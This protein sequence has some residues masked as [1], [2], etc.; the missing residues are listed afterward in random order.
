M[1]DELLF[2]TAYDRNGCQ[3][4]WVHIGYG[5]FHRAHQAVY[6]DD[7]MQKT[8]DLGWGVAAVNLR[9]SE[10]DVFQT[11]QTEEGYVLKSI[12]PSGDEAYRL[13]RSHLMFVDAAQDLETALALFACPSVHVVSMTITESGYAFTDDWRLDLT[14]EAVQADRA[15]QAPR[16]IYG[17]LAAA[18]DRRAR[19]SG[20]PLTVLCCDNIRNNGRLVEEAVHD[21]LQAAGH[22]ELAGWV[23]QNVTFPCSMVDRITP[24]SSDALVSEVADRF[25]DHAVAPV[26]AEDFS[27]WVLQDRFA[28]PMPDLARVGVQVVPNVEPFEEAKIRILNGGHTALAYFAALAGHKTFDQAMHDPRIRTH[29]DRWEMAEVLPGLNG[30]VPFDTADYLSQIACRFENA[31]IADQVERICT[32]GYAKMA[33]YIRPTMSACLDQGITPRAGYDS[34]AAWVVYARKH[35]A[36]K[37]QIPYHEPLWD[38]LSP[39]IEKG[40]EHDLAAD[41]HLWGDLPVRHDGFVPGVVA[42]IQQME[43]QWQG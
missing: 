9:A 37:A 30:I 35:K 16:T 11:A 25:P 40:R 10:S 24:R 32:D 41:R 28:G 13:V 21:F 42:A 18:F 43:D 26:H 38:K 39:L 7:Y 12:A 5:A 20:A 19:G 22:T 6:L 29:F 8:G 2:R 27:Q 3:I 36:G 33:I 34:I 4:G 17:F 14:A 15:L 23:R 31:G 1:G